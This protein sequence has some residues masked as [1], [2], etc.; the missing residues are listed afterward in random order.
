VSSPTSRQTTTVGASPSQPR[1]VERGTPRS[2]FE[3]FYYEV[4]PPV[5]PHGPA[6]SP[7][8]KVLRGGAIY[9]SFRQLGVTMRSWVG[10][11]TEFR[12]GESGKLYLAAILDLFS[13]L[14]VGWAVSAGLTCPSVECR[15]RS[16]TT[17]EPHR[18][19]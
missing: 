2:V 11:T 15:R 3:P 7:F 16:M 9:K 4:S 5:D 10:D 8:G 18:P 1:A 17:P 12:I 19:I 14:I 13:R 6:I